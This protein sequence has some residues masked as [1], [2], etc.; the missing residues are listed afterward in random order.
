MKKHNL[1]KA[2]IF[3][4]IA[5]LIVSCPNSKDDD[6]NPANGNTNIPEGSWKV[7]Q[8]I[9]SGKDE[10]HKFNGYTFVFENDGTLTSTN[11]SNTATGTWSMGS[12]DSQTKLIISFSTSQPHDDLSEDWT[13]LEKNSGIIRLQDVSG[14]NGGID[15]LSFIK[16]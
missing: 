4:S 14:G 5:V 10:T 1:L 3:I 8:Y 12:D 2:V 11:G 7:S 13:I 15:Q 6:I 16:K 9:D